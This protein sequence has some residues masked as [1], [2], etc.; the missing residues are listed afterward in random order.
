MSVLTRWTACLLLTALQG[1]PVGA[2]PSLAAVGFLDV[3]VH[4][5]ATARALAARVAFRSADGADALVGETDST[6]RLR[7]PVPRVGRYRVEVRALGYAPY[8]TVLQWAGVPSL[9][10]GLVRLSPAFDTVRV[11]APMG[12]PA[13]AE[14]GARRARGIGRYV[15]AEV[16]ADT[17]E[18]HLSLMLASRFAGVRAIP[19]DGR[20]DRYRLISTRPRGGGVATRHSVGQC[21]VDV[22]LDGAR[23]DEELDAIPPREVAGAELYAIGQAPAQYRRSYGACH[24]LLLWSRPS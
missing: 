15:A 21:P 10:V 20:S 13:L 11:V 3:S 18:T 14:Y 24:V 23:Y 19:L 22:Y 4:D 1:A 9:A 12:S 7:M 8:D 17:R 5:R 16:F 6:G 2:Q